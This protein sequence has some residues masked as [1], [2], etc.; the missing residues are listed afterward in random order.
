MK[1]T[2]SVY[3]L[4][5]FAKDEYKKMDYK[6]IIRNRE[7]R[8][9]VLNMFDFVPDEWMIRIQYRIKTG[10]KL[11][12]K[13]PH[14]FTEKI[15]W[16]KLKYRDQLMLTCADKYDVRK[17]VEMCG[18]GDILNEIY[19]IYNSP[20]EINFDKL[21]KSFVLKDTLGSGGNSVIIILDR[22][23][24]DREK[25]LKE[26]RKW[27][28]SSK[29]KS[30][31]REWV[32]DGRAHRIIAE[33][34]IEPKNKKGLIEYKLFIINGECE[35][36]YVI[37]DRD[38]GSNAR[39]GIFDKNFN[40]MP[41]VRNDELTLRD[42]VSKPDNF[43]EMIAIAKK[44]GS[45]FL[46]ARVDLYNEDNHIIFGEITFFDGSGYMKYTPDEADFYFGEKWVLK[47]KNE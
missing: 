2:T 4:A 8:L 37:T 19:G 14:R 10:R 26:M 36:L 7:C 46:E 27:I 11:N 17:Y 5:S 3:G 24:F 29:G 30:P 20:D 12:L 41:Y 6:Q 35:F 13:N 31:G 33:K 34:Y 1:S 38:L 40:L 21:P 25:V 9:R 15:Q 28:A 32:Y 39:L 44:L 47:E 22:E 23:K 42:K 18:C 43:E 45:R 16:Y